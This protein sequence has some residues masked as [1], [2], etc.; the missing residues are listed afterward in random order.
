ML[1]YIS[2]PITGIENHK[3]AFAARAA[4]LRAMGYQVENPVLIGE[5]L[6]KMFPDKKIGYAEYMTH[7]IAALLNCDGISML[8]GWEKSAG[9]KVEYEVA[10]ATGKV[11]V[12]V[13]LLEHKWNSEGR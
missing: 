13:S 7:D 4:S 10:K 12:E 3:A 6:Q 9:A 8:D 1:V 5:K 11:F 2:G